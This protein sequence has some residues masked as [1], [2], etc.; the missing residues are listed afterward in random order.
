LDL[1]NYGRRAATFTVNGANDV[2]IALP[3]LT[4]RDTA[5][6]R[7]DFL[8]GSLVFDSVSPGGRYVPNED[9]SAVA[10]MYYTVLGRA[11]EFAGEKYW[12]GIMDTQNYGIQTL[13]PYFYNSPEFQ[14]RYG[15]STTNSAFIDLLYRN[16]LGR[17]GE[18]EGTAY[19]QGQL[20]S[21]VPR[22]VVVV[23]F[24]ESVEHQA[25]RYDTIE[26]GGIV[27]GGDAF[28]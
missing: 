14:S 25:I 13:A 20:G 10:R 11:P 28:L 1:D 26:R 9:A 16:I 6:S 24:S 19:W 8:D 17:G 21:G 22:E 27:F 18:T 4:V 5:L 12:V 2:S 15:S 23:A 7:V 3:N